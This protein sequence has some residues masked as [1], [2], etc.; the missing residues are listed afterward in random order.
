MDQVTIDGEQFISEETELYVNSDWR[1]IQRGVYLR[2]E[3]IYEHEG[4]VFVVL[5]SDGEGPE[6]D[7][8]AQEVSDAIGGEL[9]RRKRD[10]QM[11]E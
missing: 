1:G 10:S 9:V 11:H 3:Q 4:E 2:V 8:L 7:I 6:Y 5:V